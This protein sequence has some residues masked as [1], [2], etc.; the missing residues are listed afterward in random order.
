MPNTTLI[1][2]TSN[3]K[4]KVTVLINLNKKYLINNLMKKYI[5]YE[6]R[7]VLYSNYSELGKPCYTYIVPGC[8][9]VVL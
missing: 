5:N 6:V 2:G 9:I 8:S 7:K 1:N 4:R 3:K